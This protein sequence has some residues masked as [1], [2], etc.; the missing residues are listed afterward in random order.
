MRESIAR[1][2]LAK[3]YPGDVGGEMEELWWDRH[4]QMYLSYA[5]AALDALLEPTDGMKEEAAFSDITF[6]YG[7][8]DSFEY[9]SAEDAGDIFVKMIRA[10]RAS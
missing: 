9:V 7:G 8:E 3:D 5:D 6:S 4:G 2:M 1:A 10:A